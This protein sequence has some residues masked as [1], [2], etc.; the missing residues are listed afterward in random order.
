[1]VAKR[2]HNQIL[3]DYDKF[4]EEWVKSGQFYYQNWQLYQN[5]NYQPV[6]TYKKSWTK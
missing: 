3:E 2:T 6:F 1:M 5:M 4:I